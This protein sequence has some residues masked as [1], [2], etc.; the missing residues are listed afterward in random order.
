MTS[1]FWKNRDKDD[2]QVGSPGVLIDN[3][4]SSNQ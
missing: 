1:K 3:G 2:W 4:T